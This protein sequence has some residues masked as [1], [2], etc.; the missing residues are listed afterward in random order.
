MTYYSQIDL[1]NVV[2]GLISIP[3]EYATSDLS[4]QAY[5]N[6]TL[7]LSGNWIKTDYYTTNSVHYGIDGKPDGGV[8]FRGT[9]GG[10]GC[11]YDPVNN[12]FYPP[13]T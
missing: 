9:W 8:P 7:N 11:T 5:I 1:N 12:V 2:T 4:G 6:N 13:N 3:D 10:V